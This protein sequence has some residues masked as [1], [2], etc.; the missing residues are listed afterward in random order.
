[1]LRQFGYIPRSFQATAQAMQVYQMFTGD[2]GEIHNSGDNNSDV[3]AGDSV[4]EQ[5]IIPI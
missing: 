3:G 4:V 1:L 5:M 2:E